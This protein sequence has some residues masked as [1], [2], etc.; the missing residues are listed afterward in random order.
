M[1]PPQRQLE[2]LREFVDHYVDSISHYKNTNDI[3]FV[4]NLL[5]NI[6]RIRRGNRFTKPCGAGVNTLAINSRGE[7]FPC[8]AFVDREEFSMGRVGME[9]PLSLHQTLAG[10]DV[11][12]QL[13]CRACWLRYDCAGGCYATHYDMT[14]HTRQPHP[15]YCQGMRAKAEV[16]FY[17]MARML[18]KCPWH[19][20]KSP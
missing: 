11:D 5:D 18:K 2:E 16:Y 14:G 19:L 17:A 1:V 3:P 12:S 10:F 13:P 20:K 8:I 6:T 15:E 7:L 4:S 9:S